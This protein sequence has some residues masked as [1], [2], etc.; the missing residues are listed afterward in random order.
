M[1]APTGPQDRLMTACTF[2]DP[3]RRDDWFRPADIGTGQSVRETV[4]AH[5]L[6]GTPTRCGGQSRACGWVPTGPGW[7]ARP[8]RANTDVCCNQLVDAVL[9][10]G[11]GG[12]MR[13][14]GGV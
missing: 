3:A 6:G 2:P 9:A 4:V 8:S 10:A 13:P 5:G 7:P 11:P 14:S 1:T 12:W